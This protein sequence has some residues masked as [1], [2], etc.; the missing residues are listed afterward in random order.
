MTV[1]TTRSVLVNTKHQQELNLLQST[2]RHVIKVL[3]RII[4]NRCEE[5][6]LM[7]VT[8]SG[9]CTYHNALRC[10]PVSSRSFLQ[11]L[12]VA[13]WSRG[14]LYGW[15]ATFGL[16]HKQM[17]LVVARR[18]HRTDCQMLIHGWNYNW[19]QPCDLR[20]THPMTCLSS[21]PQLD[22][23]TAATTL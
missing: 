20:L 9:K 17:A 5:R 16:H 15:T 14:A 21:P 13:L 8:S 18:S 19:F 10:M 4:C 3:V 2:N 23:V 6:R 12:A 1:N 22:V 7:T 11:V